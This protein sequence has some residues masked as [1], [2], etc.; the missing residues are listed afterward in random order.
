MIRLKNFTKWFLI[1]LTLAIMLAFCLFLANLYLLQSPEL[2]RTL[3]AWFSYFT[4]FDNL[5]VAGL[6][7]GSQIY[8]CHILWRLQPDGYTRSAGL[9]VLL[10]GV[11]YLTTSTLWCFPYFIGGF[12]FLTHDSTVQFRRI[13]ELEN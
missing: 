5:F 6:F 2:T 8:V 1:W 12:I 7:L 9:I 10:L 11:A 13:D 4:W 3:L